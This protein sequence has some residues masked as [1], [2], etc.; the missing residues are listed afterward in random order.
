MKQIQ[1]YK[2]TNHLNQQCVV[3]MQYGSTNSKTGN[4]IQVWI[5]PMKWIEE[6][7]SA[8]ID[9]EA[10]CMDCPHSKRA[11]KSCYVRKGYAE[12]GLMSKVKSLHNHYNNSNIELRDISELA[13]LE[14]SKCAN[15]FI[16]FGAYGEP[17]LLG[18]QN[19]KELTEVAS[20]FTGYTHQWHIPKYSWSNKYF[21]ASVETEALM[22]KAISKGFRTFRVKTTKSND[23]QMH[24]EIVCPASKEGGRKVTCNVCALCKGA[25]SKAK[26]IVINK[27]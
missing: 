26:N 15:K 3:Q 6:G 11:N 22:N 14:K 7:V 13:S 17:I 5:L 16:R 27:H 25:S 20:N 12:Y 21:M 1:L 24:N 4:S 2:T 10:S 19:I 9:D 23:T 18:E 8:M